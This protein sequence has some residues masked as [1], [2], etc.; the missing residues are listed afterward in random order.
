M[1][2]DMQVILQYAA[3]KTKDQQLNLKFGR[4]KLDCLKMALALSSSPSPSS[5]DE[6]MSE[7]LYRS[8]CRGRT[9]ARGSAFDFI[10]TSTLSPFDYGMLESVFPRLQAADRA[11]IS[12]LRD[13][14]T[15]VSRAYQ[16][17][18]TFQYLYRK[19]WEIVALK[20]YVIGRFETHLVK[21]APLMARMNPSKGRQ[22]LV[23]ECLRMPQYLPRWASS[24][25]E[26]LTPIS[27]FGKPLHSDGLW[28]ILQV[29]HLENIREYLMGII[30]SDSGYANRGVMQPPPGTQRGQAAVNPVPAGTSAAAIAT[31]AASNAGTCWRKPTDTHATAAPQARKHRH[32]K[33]RKYRER[34]SLQQGGIH[35]WED[36]G[37]YRINEL[38]SI[39]S[40]SFRTFQN[41]VD[42]LAA[43]IPSIRELLVQFVDGEVCEHW[44]H[45]AGCLEG[46]IE[47]N[48]TPIRRCTEHA[49]E[50][51]LMLIR[52]LE[53]LVKV[54]QQP[55]ESGCDLLR[56]F[57]QEQ[58]EEL[59]KKRE[60]PNQWR[61]S[62]ILACTEIHYTD[63]SSDNGLLQTSRSK[64]KHIDKL[65]NDYEALLKETRQD[66]IAFQLALSSKF[67]KRTSQIKP[68]PSTPD[69]DFGENL[70]DFCER[71]LQKT[72]FNTALAIQRVLKA[73]QNNYINSNANLSSFLQTNS[74]SYYL[75]LRQPWHAY[76]LLTQLKIQDDTGR[77]EAMITMSGICGVDKQKCLLLSLKG[78][79]VSRTTRT[80][81]PR[82]RNHKSGGLI[83]AAT[84]QPQISNHKSG[85]LIQR[86]MMLTTAASLHAHATHSRRQKAGG[87]I[88]QAWQHLAHT[89]QR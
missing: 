86:G 4:H 11:I 47:N 53:E 1:S 59:H 23:D 35:V 43:N 75:A 83:Q 24:E 79:P 31:E 82:I 7:D 25:R 33:R 77:K 44:E 72:L 78:K 30:G 28:K 51:L 38:R 15:D 16:K 71:H 52:Q 63:I 60:A 18:C 8:V 76:V 9:E 85:G 70:L 84:F 5:S 42:T 26:I 67:N 14:G 64:T 34:Q 2:R 39:L 69:R 37:P 27:V 48:D 89:L 61:L 17:P 13:A 40:R 21:I 81:Q 19:P 50:L 32:R 20:L 41:V 36:K 65:I 57:K 87:E 3:I 66:D 54:A 62:A 88:T 73:V 45:F 68:S 29:F 12:T 22:E 58:A 56:S 80:D 10:D 49:T 55:G 74:L 46:R 6:E